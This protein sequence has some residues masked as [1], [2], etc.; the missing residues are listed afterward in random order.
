MII[1]LR[2]RASLVDCEFLYKFV[3]L[4]KQLKRSSLSRN[5]FH[6]WISKVLNFKISRKCIK[7]DE[8]TSLDQ[9]RYKWISHSYSLYLISWLSLVNCHYLCH[10]YP[11][12]YSFFHRVLHINKQN[13]SFHKLKMFEKPESDLTSR[14]MRPWG[15]LSS[16]APGKYARALTY[17]RAT[18]ID[19][20]VY[21]VYTTN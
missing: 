6:H 19:L 3:V 21:V 2:Q 11:L 20:H 5:L 12:R 4:R 17:A 1:K 9:S 10:F 7:I 15:R 13:E 14:R 18:I 8:S 16:V